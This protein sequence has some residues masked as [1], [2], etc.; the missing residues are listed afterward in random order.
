MR[1]DFEF[2][3]RSSGSDGKL[4]LSLLLLCCC[5]LMIFYM[6]C[7][8]VPLFRVICVCV[9]V[10]PDVDCEGFTPMWTI[11]VEHRSRKPVECIGYSAS[12][13]RRLFD[14]PSCKR[15][16]MA[17]DKTPVCAHT[18]SFLVVDGRK[19]SRRAIFSR[20]L[21]F[22]CDCVFVVFVCFFFQTAL[23]AYIC[24]FVCLI[25]GRVRR[26]ARRIEAMLH[27]GLRR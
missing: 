23:I 24:L 14:L 3:G 25:A 10:S 11:D 4:L 15:E 1:N 18:N 21:A 13:R 7:V 17:I 22:S 6:R 5:W 2:D 9:C 16:T 12:H 27:G 20:R 26:H 8:C 19:I